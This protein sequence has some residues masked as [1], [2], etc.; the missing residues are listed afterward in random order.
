MASIQE[1]HYKETALQPPLAPTLSSLTATPLWSH[2]APQS[3]PSK[4][5]TTR[6]CEIKRHFPE[7]L[8]QLP[9]TPTLLV[10][11][12]L[13]CC[14][15]FVTSGFS[16]SLSH[17]VDIPGWRPVS[18]VHL[19]LGQ[20][21]QG[22]DHESKHF[23]DLSLVPTPELFIQLPPGWFTELGRLL[24]FPTALLASL[25]LANVHELNSHVDYCFTT[26]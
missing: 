19:L 16:S 21:L 14:S 17:T 4:G 2:Y 20:Q 26:V 9:A 13:S 23:P 1:R 7:G 3:A 25:P 15:L 12:H 24:L 22:H 11:C 8:Q 5:P 10:L 6:W 18:S